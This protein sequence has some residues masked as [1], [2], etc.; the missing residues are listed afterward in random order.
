MIRL[1][2][3]IEK[4]TIRQVLDIGTGD[5]HFIKTLTELFPEAFFTGIDP[6]EEAIQTARQ[7]FPDK[8]YRFET[9]NAENLVFPNE[10]FDLS[11]ISNALHHLATPEKALYEMKRVTRKGGWL[12]ISEIISDR[13]NAAQLNQQLYHHHRSKID[14]L[15]G[16]VHRET[17][18]RDEVLALLKENQLI[19]TGVFDYDRQEQPERNPDRLQLW[20]SK[21]E[22]HQSKAERFPEYDELKASLETFKERVM[23]DGFQPATNFVVIISNDN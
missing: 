15:S 11:T 23:K 3:I 1:T 13:L 18:S 2:E 22:Q 7:S 16:I 5:G 17:Y 21:M 14:R 10:S 8:K 20:I 9:M 12:V 4:E 6:S 19:P